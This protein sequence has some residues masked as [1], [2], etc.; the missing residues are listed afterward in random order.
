MDP[1]LLLFIL[2]PLLAILFF[3]LAGQLRRKWLRIASVLSGAACV[4]G[5]LAVLGTCAPYF[6]A[7]HL[8]SKWVAAKPATRF[9][10]ESLLSLYTLRDINP[11]QSIGAGS[12]YKLQP[13][14]RMTQYLILW[15]A[16]LDVVYRSNDT[17]VTIFCSYE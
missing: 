14:E 13:G 5:F 17:I 16:P 10:L 3:V 12:S 9:E 1:V 4:V 11:T 15:D 8:E 6:W 7:L 2:T